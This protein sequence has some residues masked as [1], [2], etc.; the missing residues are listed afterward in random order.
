[1]TKVVAIKTVRD[2]GFRTGSDL[3]SISE[4]EDIIMSTRSAIVM[5]QN[6]TDAFSSF[7]KSLF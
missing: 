6:K 5:I 3:R 7:A 2:T 4:N 1:M